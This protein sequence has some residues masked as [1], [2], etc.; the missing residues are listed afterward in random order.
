M[1]TLE[2][3]NNN[4]CLLLGGKGSWN[5]TLVGNNNFFL[6][7]SNDRIYSAF[8]EASIIIQGWMNN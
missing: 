5:H 4:T 1:A 7:F 8:L 6:L 3:Q 2:I